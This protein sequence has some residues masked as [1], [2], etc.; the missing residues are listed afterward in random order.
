[1]IMWMTI[2]KCCNGQ[3]VVITS[4]R[5]PCSQVLA[6]GLYDVRL[7]DIIILYWCV[8][9]DSIFVFLRMYLHLICI[10]KCFLFVLL[11]H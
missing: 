7:M 11:A 9:V 3:R 6:G 10:C 2:Q 8:W 5:F 4:K 1:M